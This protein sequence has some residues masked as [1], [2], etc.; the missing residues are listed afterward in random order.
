MEITIPERIGNIYT[1]TDGIF[2][3]YRSSISAVTVLNVEEYTVCI[4]K[5]KVTGFLISY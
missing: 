1:M 2:K 5:R 3:K 4:S